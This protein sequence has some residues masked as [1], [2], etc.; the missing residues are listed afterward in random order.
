MAGVNTS[1]FFDPLSI[2]CSNCSVKPG[3]AD[4]SRIICDSITVFG[5]STPMSRVM[6]SLVPA[7]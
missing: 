6:R 1:P 7:R 5:G 2:C 4:N 3:S